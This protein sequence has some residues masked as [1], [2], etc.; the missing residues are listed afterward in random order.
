MGLK[1]RFGKTITKSGSWCWVDPRGKVS[2]DI[3][4]EMRENAFP[5]ARELSSYVAGV[6]DSIDPS[7]Y[8]PLSLHYDKSLSIDDVNAISR[9]MRYLQNQIRDELYFREY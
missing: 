6:L 9:G 5:C 7:L 3:V 8:S 4:K 1:L 2:D